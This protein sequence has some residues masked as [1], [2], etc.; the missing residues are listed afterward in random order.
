MTNDKI[1]KY[2][3]PGNKFR[4]LN[5]TSHLKLNDNSLQPIRGETDFLFYCTG[6]T[7]S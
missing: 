4:S 1:L 5:K 3:S 7:L 2:G 6:I